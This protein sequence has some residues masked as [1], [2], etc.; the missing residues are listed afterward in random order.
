MS[1]C[2]SLYDI[3]G[4]CSI[5]R[6][7]NS[8]G[9]ARWK[10]LN[11]IILPVLL[12][13]IRLRRANSPRTPL[14]SS[15]LQITEAGWDKCFILALYTLVFKM[16]WFSST[17]QWQQIK[18]KIYILFLYH[19]GFKFIDLNIWCTLKAIAVIII[20]VQM[21]PSLVYGSLFSLAP[22][23][24][25]HD[26]VSLDSFFPAGTSWCPDSACVGS[27]PGAL[28]SEGKKAPFRW[29]WYLETTSWV[30]GL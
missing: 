2:L 28:L 27:R 1:G 14:D 26:P 16:S 3:N 22:K 21:M 23:S 29:K 19:C 5:F 13:G 8:W 6:S 30:L 17:R 25:R 12:A 18:L 20:D 24:L 11:L 4:H 9:V 15:E 7:L 10:S